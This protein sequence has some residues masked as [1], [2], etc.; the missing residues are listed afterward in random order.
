MEVTVAS[1][2][3]KGAGDGLWQNLTGS[4][5]GLAVNLLI[6]PLTVEAVG[7][8]AMLDFGRALSFGRGDVHLSARLKLEIR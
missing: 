5:K 4:V 8:R 7:H 2:K 3:N 6:P 1:V